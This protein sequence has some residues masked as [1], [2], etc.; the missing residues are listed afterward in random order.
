MWKKNFGWLNKTKM[1]IVIFPHMKV[2]RKEVVIQTKTITPT[3]SPH[4]TR[5]HTH[6]HTHATHTIPFEKT[7]ANPSASYRPTP[8]PTKQKK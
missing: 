7:I 5:S 3:C 8:Q 1:E 4:N 6:T 2:P